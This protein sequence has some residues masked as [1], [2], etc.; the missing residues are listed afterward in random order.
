MMKILI[1]ICMLLTTTSLT[2]AGTLEIPIIPPK[3]PLN[4]Q[5]RLPNTKLTTN[6]ISLKI[7][8]PEGALTGAMADRFCDHGQA[9]FH[10]PE[11]PEFSTKQFN[12]PLTQKSASLGY[13]TYSP[14]TSIFEHKIGTD[15]DISI[16][17]S[18]TDFK[19]KTCITDYFNGSFKIYGKAYIAGNIEAKLAQTQEIIYKQFVDNS[20]NAEKGSAM[21]LVDFMTSI[22]DALVDAI[23]ADPKYVDAY[24]KA[25]DPAPQIK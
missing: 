14:D 19:F 12:R 21:D 5:S 16:A 2:Y 18:I 15:A 6:I 11:E 23:L 24:L 13:S 4:I 7:D 9:I 25:H 10:N 3:Q 8:L 17:I 20:V 22:S 1:L